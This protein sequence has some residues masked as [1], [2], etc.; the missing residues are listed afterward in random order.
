MKG[1]V[2]RAAPLCP[3]SGGKVGFSWSWGRTIPNSPYS[4]FLIALEAPP[5]PRPLQCGLAASPAGSPAFWSVSG[6]PLLLLVPLPA[7]VSQRVFR[8]TALLR[9]ACTPPSLGFRVL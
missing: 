8:L 4:G 9:L 7:C 2:Q 5:L 1:A 6:A 3:G